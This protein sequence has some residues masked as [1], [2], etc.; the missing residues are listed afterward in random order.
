MSACSIVDYSS[1]LLPITTWV[2]FS[3]TMAAGPWAAREMSFTLLLRLTRGNLGNNNP[4]EAVAQIEKIRSQ[5]SFS[6]PP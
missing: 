3:A 6:M 4:R 5:L 1:G 2:L